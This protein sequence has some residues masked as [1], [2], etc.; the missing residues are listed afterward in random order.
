MATRYEMS[1]EARKI[2]AFLETT[3]PGS[4]FS[5]DYLRNLTGIN[6][7]VTVRARFYTAARRAFT[8]WQMRFKCIRGVGY[9]RL[10]EAGKNSE[11]SRR[12]G[13]VHRSVKRA[14]RYHSAVEAGK[15]DQL[16]KLENAVNAMQL[17]T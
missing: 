4:Q 14:T 17:A 11:V 8:Q 2:L 10:N 15:L 13:G 1:E 3:S 12:I 16:G 7:L 5:Y 9:T 6:D